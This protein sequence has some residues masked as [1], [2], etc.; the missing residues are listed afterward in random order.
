MVRNDDCE[1]L[2]TRIINVAP[3][4][5]F[6]LDIIYRNPTD[7]FNET[8]QDE[9]DVTIDLDPPPRDVFQKFFHDT[10]KFSS[11]QGLS[12]YYV[13]KQ[14]PSMGS[15]LSPIMSDLFCHMME[16]KIILRL[17]E[18][19]T[20][21][22]YNRYVDDCILI[23]RKGAE[24]SIQNAMNSFDHFL[25]FTFETMVNNEL[26]FLDTCIYLDSQ[27]IPQIKF[28]RKPSASD[29]KM[30]FENSVA[31]KSTKFLPLPEKFSWR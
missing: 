20:I 30:N 10:L 19:G 27:N 14:G 18:N 21:L 12:G 1:H 24:N 16:S 6:I 3:F 29:V 31:L 8:I 2:I 17:L 15:R 7:F 4:I 13:Q 26:P 25:K 5:S 11:F 23:I 28:Y 9:N 22:H